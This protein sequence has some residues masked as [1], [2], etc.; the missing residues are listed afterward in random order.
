MQIIKVDSKKRHQVNA[1][2]NLHFQIYKDIPQWVPPLE[3]ELRKKFDREHH[4]FYKH[5]DAVFFMAID[6]SGKVRGR[7]AVIDNRNFN[8]YNQTAKAFFY[9]FECEND[10]SVAEA[11]FD[12]AYDWARSRGLTAIMGPRGFNALDGQGLL[13]KG[14]EHRPAFG[15]PYNPPYYRDLIETLG[16]EVT[17]EVTSGYMD[18]TM[19]L[20]ERVHKMAEKVKQRRGLEVRNFK[21]RRDLHAFASHVKELYNDSLSEIAGNPPLTDDE[22]EGMTNQIIWF[23]DPK[24][25]KVVYKDDNPV[26]FL[27]AYPD[28]SA[29]VQRNNGK[30]LPFGWLDILLELRKTKWVILNGVGIKK[31]YRGLGGTVLMYSEIEKS[32][33]DGGF[34]YADL[35]QT[36]LENDKIQREMQGY[37]IKFYKKHLVYT[38]DL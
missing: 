12:A 10:K 24:I 26:G 38:R 7:I 5:S 11:L 21:N 34:E 35:V 36:G 33:L 2:I 15:V 13:V 9:L 20:P 16:F 22:V 31:E 8:E 30:L 6:D 3:F 19:L 18:R 25:I 28:I 4:S 29:A 37:K 23:A 27:L 32:L 17:R 1:F 14:F